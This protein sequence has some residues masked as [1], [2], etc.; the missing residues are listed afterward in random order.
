MPSHVSGPM[1]PVAGRPS[2]DWCWRLTI[3]SLPENAVL[4]DGGHL[5]VAARDDID[6]LL[7]LPHGFAAHPLDEKGFRQA[8]ELPSH[9]CSGWE[10]STDW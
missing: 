2:S 10:S 1:A 6:E 7:R 5:G 3:R 9:S 4:R 8:D